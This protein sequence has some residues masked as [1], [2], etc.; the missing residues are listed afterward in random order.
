[1]KKVSIV[2]IKGGVGKTVS[3]VNIAASLGELNKKVLIVDADAQSNAT[4]YLNCYSPEGISTY[5]VLMDKDIDVNTVIKNTN[6]K[7]VSIIPANI[8]LICENEIVNDTRRSRENRL[9]KALDNVKEEYDYVIIDCPPSLGIITTNALVASDYVLVPIKIDQFALDGFG[10]LLDTIDEISN[11]FNPKLDFTGAF[12]T[13]DKRTAI[14]RKMKA[15]L[16]E[17]LKDKL[18]NVSIRE[19]VKVVQSTFEQQPV[20]TYCK[21]AI[22]SK[23]YRALTQEVM[24]HVI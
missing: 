23:D 5:D 24:K 8:K 13:M 9:K 2:N 16:K 7:G 22:S 19:N 17:A 18:F 6:V 10:Y 21:N 12:I 14:N 20:I 3:T 15:K 11:E 1:M 4:Q